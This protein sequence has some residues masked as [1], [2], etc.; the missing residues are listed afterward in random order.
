MSELLSQNEI[1]AL[2]HGARD[3]QADMKN[4]LAAE[5]FSLYDL[6]SGIHRAQGWTQYVEIIDDRI[7]ASLS[8]KLLGILHK[9]VDVRRQEIQIQKFGDYVKTLGVPTS[10]NSYLLSG[11]SGAWV[12]VLD[13]NLVYALVNAFFGGGTR[14]SQIEGR[15]F[16]HTEQRVINLILKT[17]IDAIKVSFKEIADREFT[18]VESEMNPAH[19]STYSDSDVL[20]IRPFKVEFSGAGGEIQLLMP[21]SAVESIFRHKHSKLSESGLSSRDALQAMAKNFVVDVT[22]ELRG[23]NLTISEVFK[24]SEGDI[25]GI[26]KPDQVD[27][28]INGIAKLK[29]RMGEVNGKVGIEILQ[30]DQHRN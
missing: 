3:S 4:G 23:A 6:T 12:I 1:D 25:V 24:L 10:I 14:P 13:A 20:M 8:N 2:L 28:K 7:Q 9:S 27:V 11:M 21:G 29:A 16:S 18:I 19:L 15:E 17:I 22:G 26:A 5:D 30:L